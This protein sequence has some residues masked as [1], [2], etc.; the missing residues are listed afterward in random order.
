MVSGAVQV[1][2]PVDVAVPFAQ[3]HGGVVVE[4]AVML[5]EDRVDEAAQ[6]LRDGQAVALVADDEVDEPGAT[7][8]SSD[9]GA[10]CRRARAA[11]GPTFLPA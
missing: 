11:R 4:S 2:A 10:W 8:K 1:L 7:L 6:G 5:V 9:S 3:Q